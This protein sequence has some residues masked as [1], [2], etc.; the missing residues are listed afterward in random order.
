MK[1]SDPP[2]H[3]HHNWRWPRRSK[4]WTG[5]LKQAK[6]LFRIYERD[7][8]ASF[9]AQGYRIRIGED[10][11]EALKQLLPARLFEAFEATCA[12][13][14][15][16]GHAVNAATGGELEFHIGPDVGRSMVVR[17]ITPIVLCCGTCCCMDLRTMLSL[18]SGL[19]VTSYVAVT[20]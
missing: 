20:K 4:S 9:R 6:I 12:E 13:V 3:D 16:G 11:A 17:R 18:G 8:N 7:T 19:S 15:H 14:I 2:H 10:G 5:G 1:D